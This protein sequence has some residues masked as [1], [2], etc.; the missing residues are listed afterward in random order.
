MSLKKAVL[1]HN[2]KQS[3]NAQKSI[4]KTTST[5]KHCQ[6]FAVI[7]VNF[8]AKISH[9]DSEKI[10]Q[11]KTVQKKQQNISIQNTFMKSFLTL[12]CMSESEVN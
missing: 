4:F 6:N 12:R 10:K 3:N 11:N 1:T 9:H 7:I 8:S 2:S 5:E